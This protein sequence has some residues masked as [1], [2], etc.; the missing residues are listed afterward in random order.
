MS[1]Q[2]RGCEELDFFQVRRL[3]DGDEAEFTQI[4]RLIDRASTV[5]YVCQSVLAQYEPVH[6]CRTQIHVSRT[7]VS[8]TAVSRTGGS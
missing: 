8:R 2:R 1:D 5:I 4:R 3:D 6:P 7:A